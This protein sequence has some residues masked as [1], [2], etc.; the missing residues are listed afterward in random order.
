MSNYQKLERPVAN[1]TEPVILKFGLTLQQIMDVDEKNQ[2][3]TT[4]VWLNLVSVLLF[5]FFDF[6]HF[7]RLLNGSEHLPQ[8]AC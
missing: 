4:N 5:F 3:L 7:D 1:E 8:I 2:I 6:L